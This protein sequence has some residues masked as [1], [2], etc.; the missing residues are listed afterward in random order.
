M[1][2]VLL[3]FLCL[4]L[5]LGVSA[6]PPVPQ[7][8]VDDNQSEQKSVGVEQIYLAKDDGEG[9]AGDEATV[10]TTKDVPIY[11]VVQ[12]TSTK[13]AT[14]KMN[15]I[16]VKVQGVK[17]ETK[18]VTVSFKTNGKQ[19]RVSF[20]GSPDGDWVAGSYRVDIFLDGK[21][22]GSRELE[23]QKPV[24]ENPVVKAFQPKTSVAKPKA[25]TKRMRKN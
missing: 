16:A 20:T 23:I 25:A 14:V 7:P 19:N 21:L 22:V 17:S 1:K 10:F 5:H 13:P 9:N 24:G 3:I 6:Q 18:V 15:F 12:L 11:C 8:Q 4:F 2:F